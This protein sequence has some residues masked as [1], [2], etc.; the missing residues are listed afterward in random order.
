MTERPQDLP[1]IRRQ[2]GELSPAERVEAI[3][4]SGRAAELVRAL[5]EQELYMTVHEAGL[6]RALALLPHASTEQLVFFSDLEGWSEGSFEPSA[7]ARWFETLHRADPDS[8][9]RWLL[10][11]DETLVVLE[12]SR[13]LRV[14][15]LDES[16]DQ[17]FWPPENRQLATHDGI[18]YLEPRSEDLAIAFPPIWEAFAHLRSGHSQA[19]EALLEQ[20]LWVLPSEQEENAY[21]ERNSRLAE[22]G[23]PELDEAI[24]VWAPGH[25]ADRAHRHR[26]AQRLADL[27]PLA[28]GSEGSTL[29]LLSHAPSGLERLV[30]ASALIDERRRLAFGQAL[31]RLANRFSVASLSHLGAPETHHEGLYT[32]LSHLHLALDEL[33]ADSPEKAA[34][35]MASMPTF[36][37]ARIGTG[38]VQ[39]RAARARAMLERGWLARVVHG[40]SRLDD[41]LVALFEGLVA[42]RPRFG[43]G[44]VA[45][46]YRGR[47]DLE[48]ADRTLDAIEA[49][50]EVLESA[51]GAGADDLP[52]F[53]PLPDRRADAADMEWS[54]VLLTSIA[55]AVLGREA[56]P[57]PLS[58]EDAREALALLLT[59][60]QPRRVSEEFSQR[61]AELGVRDALVPLLAERLEADAGE[62]AP[63]A[64]PDTRLVRALLFRLG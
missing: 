30:R 19:Y 7:H 9:V 49:L 47:E 43:T 29:P 31:V 44:E 63:D 40:E 24:E 58:R 22:K 5:G 25:L 45:R 4:A 8:L 32:A 34:R 12:L 52:E 57:Q 64:L 35:A 17:A 33:G 61:C 36:D 3:E 54:A 1:E 18:Y 6:D 48:Q 53:T 42:H 55:N 60:D 56:R 26:I 11:A 51:L 10:E 13:L 27:P 46:P 21:E 50:G 59:P 2:L 28:G 16:T 39:E 62:L 15:K 20:V 37:L 38:A 14:Y 41:E 23:F